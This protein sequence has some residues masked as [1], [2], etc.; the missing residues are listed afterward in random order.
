MIRQ[1]VLLGA[2]GLFC[3]GCGGNPYLEASLDPAKYEGKSQAWF[4]ENWGKP[5]GKTS[6]FF[7]G[8]KWIYLRIAGGETGF[9]FFNFSPNQCKITLEFDEDQTLEDYDYTDC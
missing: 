3:A 8:E 7:G 6:R 1:Y 9:L 5:S 2:F 4:E